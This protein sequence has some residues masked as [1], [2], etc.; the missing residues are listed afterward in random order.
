MLITDLK[1][2]GNNFYKFRKRLGLTQ[3]EVAEKAEMSDRTYADIERGNVNMRIETFIQICNALLITP[4]DVLV[5][6]DVPYIDRQTELVKRLE[7]CT[8]RERE[9]SFNILSAYFNSLNKE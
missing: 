7:L 2:I 3:G 9:T 8:P 6:N 4:N 1:S 5:N